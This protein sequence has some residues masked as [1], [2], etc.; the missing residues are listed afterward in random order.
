[1]LFYFYKYL[2][3]NSQNCEQ[4]SLSTKLV[5][6]TLMLASSFGRVLN[7]YAAISVISK[8]PCIRTIAAASAWQ[9]R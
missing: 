3:Q 4:L 9:K 1:M 6:T 5:T 2:Q 8:V 7:I